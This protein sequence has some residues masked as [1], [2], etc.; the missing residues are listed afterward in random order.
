MTSYAPRCVRSW[1]FDDLGEASNWWWVAG[2]GGAKATTA[3][4]GGREVPMEGGGGHKR[5]W[6]SSDL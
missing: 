5:G 2:R 3:S 4:E 1:T 6:A